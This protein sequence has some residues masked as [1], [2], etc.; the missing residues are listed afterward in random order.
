MQY[1]ISVVLVICF[2]Y[3]KQFYWNWCSQVFHGFSDSS[4]RLVW[5]VLT[6]STSNLTLHTSISFFRPTERVEETPSDLVSKIHN[7]CEWLHKDRTVLRG[8][9]LHGKYSY[10]VNW[11]I[12]DTLHDLECSQIFRQKDF[13][14]LR[15]IF[16]FFHQ[17][18]KLTVNRQKQDVKSY[19]QLLS[20]YPL[21]SIKITNCQSSH[22][23]KSN[24]FCAT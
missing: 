7:N 19:P 3:L 24:F 5:N 11:W 1:F 12:R 9:L 23:F 17:F 14:I 18:W 8:C 10:D 21:G 13:S 4:T 2:K 22:I 15:A 6:F 20:F 16:K